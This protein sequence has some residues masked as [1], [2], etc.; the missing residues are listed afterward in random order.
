MLWLTAASAKNEIKW[1]KGLESYRE[2]ERRETMEQRMESRKA[3]QHFQLLQ[4]ENSPGERMAKVMPRGESEPL[5]Q[6]GPCAQSPGSK[7]I[8]GVRKRMV[9]HRER[10][11]LL[12]EMEAPGRFGGGPCHDQPEGARRGPEG[13]GK[14]SVVLQP[15]QCLLDAKTAELGQV[16]LGSPGHQAATRHPT[17]L[18][19]SLRSQRAGTPVL[20]QT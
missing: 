15:G 8:H 16:A 14:T 13:Y 5:G 20:T 11:G 12:S 17:C 6:P 10:D 18:A 4:R 7:T 1:D 2:R 19:S 9:S 3:T